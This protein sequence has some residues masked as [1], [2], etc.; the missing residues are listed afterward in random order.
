MKDI[1]TQIE[2]ADEIQLNDIIRAVMRR[3]RALRTDREL[4]FLSLPTDPKTRNEELEK[5]IRYI[6]SCYNKQDSQ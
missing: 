3:Y 2:Q 6:R 5:L 1:V 4:S